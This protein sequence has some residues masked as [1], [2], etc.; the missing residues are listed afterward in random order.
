LGLC[1][2]AQCKSRLSGLSFTQSPSPSFTRQDSN[3]PF[4]YMTSFFLNENDRKNKRR[5]LVVLEQRDVGNQILLALK[6][7]TYGQ[8]RIVQI[9]SLCS[10]YMATC[11]CSPTTAGCRRKM[12]MP[13]GG[14]ARLSLYVTLQLPTGLLM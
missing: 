3:K 6:S 2:A 13:R 14:S 5:L 1:V 11:D 8:Y 12:P 7:S 9:C 10:C 4:P